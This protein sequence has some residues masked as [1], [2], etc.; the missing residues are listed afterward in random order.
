MVTVIDGQGSKTAIPEAQGY[1]VTRKGCLVIWGDRHRT[2][3]TFAPGA[4]DS[5]R[6]QDQ[7]A[8]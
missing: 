1:R 5:I 6:C 7:Q 4:W 2:L 3:A 8:Q